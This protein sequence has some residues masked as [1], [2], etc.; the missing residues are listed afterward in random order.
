MVLLQQSLHERLVA[1]VSNGDQ[2]VYKRIVDQ[3]ED[4]QR[5]HQ[6]LIRTAESGVSE[7]PKTFES[8]QKEDLE[9]IQNVTFKSIKSL[10]NVFE[11]MCSQYRQNIISE[12]PCVS[13]HINEIE[14]QTKA[15]S[16]AI[17]HHVQNAIHECIRTKSN[18]TR[19]VMNHD[20]VRHTNGTIVIK[21]DS[22]CG[23]NTKNILKQLER[24]KQYYADIIIE[25]KNRILSIEEENQTTFAV[26]S[27]KMSNAMN[28]QMKCDC[29][30]IVCET[31]SKVYIKVLNYEDICQQT[32]KNLTIKIED[33]KSELSMAEEKRNSILS[34]WN[35]FQTQSNEISVILADSI[36]K[37]IEMNDSLEVLIQQKAKQLHHLNNDI[38][39]IKKSK[40]R[41]KKKKTFGELIL[42]KLNIALM[43]LEKSKD[44]CRA[45]TNEQDA[46]KRKLM[47]S[48]KILDENIEKLTNKMISEFNKVFIE[49]YISNLVVSEFYSAQNVKLKI[50]N[51]LF[52]EMTIKISE[53]EI[54]TNNLRRLNDTSV[55]MLKQKRKKRREHEENQTKILNLEVNE[56]RKLL[57]TC[58]KKIENAKVNISRCKD[59]FTEAVHVDNGLED[60]IKGLSNCSRNLMIEN[61][62][63]TLVKII[64][65]EKE[66][67]SSNKL[68]CMCL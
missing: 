65:E 50:P 60:C 68:N 34:E 61:H 40:L 15:D 18:I 39:K 54:E 53:L 49:N 17:T 6:E 3:L 33:C 62:G 29:I 7:D 63:K 37:Y 58:N 20:R 1:F 36:N 42:Q 30:Q 23:N 46:Y 35:D 48:I 25:L 28:L 8:K 47:S 45:R 44:T 55:D 52:D 2:S 64:E 13:N 32:G 56:R 43:A 67:S 19:I 9:S 5:F 22:C 26:F 27:Q 10:L 21:W 11:S 59:L 24:Q 14:L 16:L 12:K 41:L 57:E 51:V 66:V 38:H 4:L 31:C